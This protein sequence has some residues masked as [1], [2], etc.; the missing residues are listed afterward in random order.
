MKNIQVKF[1]AQPK[2]KKYIMFKNKEE[3]QEE[4]ERQTKLKK[5]NKYNFEKEANIELKNILKLGKK[6]MFEIEEKNKQKSP[7]KFSFETNEKNLLE[8]KE[9]TSQKNKEKVYLVRNGKNPYVIIK[10]SW[11]LRTKK[12]VIIYILFLFY[13][14]LSFE[15]FLLLIIL[16]FFWW[17]KNKKLINLKESKVNINNKKN[18]KY[19]NKIIKNNSFRYNKKN[20]IYLI[21]VVISFNQIIFS[22]KELNF[23]E[24]NFS[25]I[26]L[27]I[28]GIGEKK[29]FS[30]DAEYFFI[31]YNPDIVYI[32]G[33]RQNIVNYS[34][35][36]NQTDNFVE[37]IWN[38]S[39]D[40]CRAM[41]YRCWDITEINLT[42]FDNSK[43]NITRSMFNACTKLTSLDLS[44]FN[45]TN[46]ADMADMFYNC[47]SLT[48]IDLSNFDTSKVEIMEYMFYACTKLEYINLKYFTENKSLTV[49]DF[50][51]DVPDNIVICLNEN[52]TKILTEL[53]KINCYVIDCSDNWQI[54]QKKKVNKSGIC[55]DNYDND[56]IYNY[57]YN[58]TFYEYCLNGNLINNS[59][60]KSCY[61]DNKTNDEKYFCDI[62]DFFNQTRTCKI[63]LETVDEEIVNF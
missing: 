59:T 45:T 11:N 58:G 34:Y 42:N 15:H 24:S 44:N 25:S 13:L 20:I 12:E 33:E 56:I 3:I 50:F 21:I 27:K 47:S 8:M 4:K 6:T 41:F 48:S 62:S 51:Y 32:N 36:F 46:V 52:N 40:Y 57:I 1:K 49:K 37:L 26:T 39:I 7:K 18:I 9:I 10:K 23:T 5:G 30:S 14:G 43:V 53:K 60:I 63:N 61:Y 19:N 22:N 55:I 28:N 29:V 2:D 54:N 17:K 31:L 35:Y 38:N 16:S